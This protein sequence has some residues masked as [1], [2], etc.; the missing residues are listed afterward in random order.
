MDWCTEAILGGRDDAIQPCREFAAAKKQQA[1]AAAEK[2]IADAAAADEASKKADNEA[3]A[4][5]N[6]VTD[7]YTA[8]VETDGPSVEDII[9]AKKMEYQLLLLQLGKDKENAELQTKAGTLKREIEIMEK[10][11]ADA[12]KAER[13]ANP[14]AAAAEDRAVAKAE[15]QREE[16]QRLPLEDEN[17]IKAEVLAAFKTGDNKKVK[18]VREKYKAIKN[19]A[20][21]LNAKTKGSDK[22]VDEKN[23]VAD[24]FE[25]S[26]K[27]L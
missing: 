10:E 21:E 12:K 11:L 26:K 20:K 27:A 3:A 7:A 1:D 6:G 23:K 24:A 4:A 14:A 16:A 9:K 8:K 13:E 22:S 25:R 2:A 5:E 19:D 18:A 17:A 15:R